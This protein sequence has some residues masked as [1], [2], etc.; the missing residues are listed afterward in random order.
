MGERNKYTEAIILTVREQGESNR[1]V[2]V[3]SPDM[4][5]FYATLYGGPK[6]RL[7]S[8]VQPFNTGTIFIYDDENRNL[9]KI[10]DFDAKHFHTSLKENLY[11]MWAAN[12]ASEVVMKTK[13]AGDDKS[14]YTLLKAFI[15]GIDAGDERTAKIGTARFLW[16][17][18][19]LLGVQPDVSEC[20]GCGRGF[21]DLDSTKKICFS[22]ALNGF[23]C[24]DCQFLQQN[25]KPNGGIFFSLTKEASVYMDAIN[26]LSPGQ[27]RRMPLSDESMDDFRRLSFNLIEQAVGTTLLTMKSGLGIL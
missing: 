1:S 5:I 15:D 4:G 12:L 16:R 14:A 17:Y 18:L 26:N 25:Q 22:P 2:C 21:S 7:R 23:L 6:S 10:S 20:C 13:C 24:P 9:K 3:F 19:S 27:V 11:K 8:L